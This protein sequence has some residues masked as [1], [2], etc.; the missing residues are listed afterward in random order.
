MENPKNIMVL[1]V[2]NV[3]NRQYSVL[4]CVTASTCLSKSIAHDVAANLKN[5]T[6]G[7]ELNQYTEMI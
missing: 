1:T 6:I 7:G 3:P 5:W 4:G 2:E